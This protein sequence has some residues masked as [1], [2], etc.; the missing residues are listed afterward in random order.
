[1]DSFNELRA[2]SSSDD[3]RSGQIQTIASVL[4][5]TPIVPGL[6]TTSTK[7]DDRISLHRQPT[8]YPD[9]RTALVSTPFPHSRVT[10]SGSS[11]TTAAQSIPTTPG[12]TTSQGS[13]RSAVV[14]TYPVQTRN[15]L[16]VGIPAQKSSPRPGFF[17][18]AKDVDASHSN[19][20]DIAGDQVNIDI[21]GNV[22]IN[23]V[24]CE[25]IERLDE[26]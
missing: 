7:I 23:Q 20:N 4:S 17:A 11:V 6:D 25:A 8:Q 15:Q 16:E 18:G 5:S 3:L 26:N 1:M 13:L 22:I 24:C 14:T 10:E 2:E 12:P 19:F 9:Q 21:A